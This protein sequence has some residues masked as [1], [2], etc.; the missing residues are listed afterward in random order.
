[1]LKFTLKY[2]ALKGS[3]HMSKIS[4]VKKMLSEHRVKR[5]HKCQYRTVVLCVRNCGRNRGRHSGHFC[6]KRGQ[7]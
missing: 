3:G 7:N 6:S 1:M 2:H 5:F 4:I